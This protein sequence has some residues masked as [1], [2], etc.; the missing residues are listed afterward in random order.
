MGDFIDSLKD[1]I[2][3]LKQARDELRVQLHI[4][5]ADIKDRWHKLEDKWIDVDGRA[6]QIGSESFHSIAEAT[7]RLVDELKRDYDELKSALKD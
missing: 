4:G 7:Q 5:K 2:E 3:N 6:K 1:D